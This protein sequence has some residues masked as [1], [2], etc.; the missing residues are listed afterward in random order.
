[1]TMSNTTPRSSSSPTGSLTM[2]MCT[3]WRKQGEVKCVVGK[4]HVFIRCSE[5]AYVLMYQWERVEV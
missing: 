1:M 2:W 4:A 3:N 5:P